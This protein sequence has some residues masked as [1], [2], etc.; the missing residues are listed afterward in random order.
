MLIGGRT[1]DPLTTTAKRAMIRGQTNKQ[2][3][4]QMTI[5]SS[6]SGCTKEDIM[7]MPE[8]KLREAV[9]AAFSVECRN[10]AENDSWVGSFLLPDEIADAFRG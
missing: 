9:I 4:M 6:Y 7:N 1:V 10:F 3:T 2:R 5:I 8:D